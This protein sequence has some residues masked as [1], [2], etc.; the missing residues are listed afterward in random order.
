MLFQV[1]EV[2]SSCIVAS[3]TEQQRKLQEAKFEILTSEGSYIHSLNVLETHF[4]RKLSEIIGSREQKLLFSN[5]LDVRIP[6]KHLFNHSMSYYIL[7]VEKIR[8]FFWLSST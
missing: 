2:E 7:E 8:M 6:S 5:I 4:M 1:P 3:L